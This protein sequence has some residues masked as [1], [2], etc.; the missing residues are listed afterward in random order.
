[1]I[2]GSS[3]D[4]VFRKLLPLLSKPQQDII[5][6]I[7]TSWMINHMVY[8]DDDDSGKRMVLGAGASQRY[9]II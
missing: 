4:R 8:L 6:T 2:V 7:D 5:K 1:M 9:E 3:F